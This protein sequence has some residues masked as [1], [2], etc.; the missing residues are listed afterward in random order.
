MR[1]IRL[2]AMLMVAYRIDWVTRTVR[3][4]SYQLKGIDTTGILDFISTFEGNMFHWSLFRKMRLRLLISKV[5]VVASK[6]NFDF[7]MHAAQVSFTFIN[8]ICTLDTHT[9]VWDLI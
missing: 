7:T 3:E 9:L 8:E 5:G 4:S 2:S 6:E 1:K